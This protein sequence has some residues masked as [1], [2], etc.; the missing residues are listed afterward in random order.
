M[1]SYCA[2]S[3]GPVDYQL[4]ARHNDQA[5]RMKVKFI[6]SMQKA[7]F[8]LTCINLTFFLTIFLSY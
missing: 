2:F 1:T 6:L 8:R 5:I 3:H 4:S 7:M